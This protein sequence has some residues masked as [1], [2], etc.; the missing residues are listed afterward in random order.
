MVKF[1]VI[2]PCLNSEKYIAETVYSIINQTALLSHRAELE[3]I[4][5]DGNSSDRT[6][7]IIKEISRDF[8]NG[9]ITIISENDSGM[10]DALAKGLSKA[11]GE[12][13]SYLNAGDIYALT[14]F[15]I[16]LDI[17]QAKENI[18]WLTGCNVMYNENNAIINFSLPFKYRKRFFN[19]GYYG[20]K[21]PFVQQESTFWDYKLNSI[22]DLNKLSQ[23]R[24]AGDYYLWT[25]FSKECA[26]NI[27]AAYLGGFKYHK[28]QL[29]E[30]IQA[31][32]DEMNSMIGKPSFLDDLIALFDRLIWSGP[33]R[34][35]KV[36]NRDNLLIFDHS[37]QDWI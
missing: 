22:I 31:Y 28:G 27:V 30:N 8:Q 14:A 23:F 37:T 6:I 2:T 32:Y 15:D 11:S 17:F 4:V 35:K 9:R 33:N 5:V 24:F 12:I 21:L 7:E 13:Y 34:I 1:S 26:L 19:C 3:Y 36:L 10:Y 25:Q 18:R 20:K 16:V 29:S